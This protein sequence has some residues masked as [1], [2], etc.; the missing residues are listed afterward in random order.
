MIIYMTS[1][2]SCLS[3]YF[4]NQMLSCSIILRLFRVGIDLQISILSHHQLDN[5]VSQ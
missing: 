5:E 4:F 1:L 2:N 3:L